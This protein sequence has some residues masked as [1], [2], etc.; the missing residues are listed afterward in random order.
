[1]DDSERAIAK[2]RLQSVRSLDCICG[3]RY[4]YESE[5]QRPEGFYPAA[6]TSKRLD[7]VCGET[8]LYSGGNPRLL[9]AIEPENQM[10][11]LG[12]EIKENAA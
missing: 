1:M 4:I 8:L 6:M 12:R 9:Y 3:I 10:I 11:W 2:G 7:C 5:A